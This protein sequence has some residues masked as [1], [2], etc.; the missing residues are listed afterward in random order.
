MIVERGSHVEVHVRVH[1]RQICG[2]PVV[3]IAVQQHH[4]DPEG[5]EFADQA[6]EERRIGQVEHE[7]RVAPPHVELDRHS[8]FQGDVRAGPDPVPEENGVGEPRCSRRSRRHERP[9]RPDHVLARGPGRVECEATPIRR[10][11]FEAHGVLGRC[12][13]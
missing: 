12:A 1:R 13:Q 4:R 6:G 3:G 11:G 5:V 9:R 7:V 10:D 8:S 2:L